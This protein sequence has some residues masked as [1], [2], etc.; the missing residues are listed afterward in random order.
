[1][2]K[3]YYVD[4]T[5]FLNGQELYYCGYDYRPRWRYGEIPELQTK[6]YNDFDEVYNNSVL[7]NCIYP[8]ETFWKHRKYLR[9]GI[10]WDRNITVFEKD[11]KEV[12]VIYR[13][14][15]LENYTMEKLMKELY[16]DEFV[17]YC[18]DH[19]MSVCPIGGV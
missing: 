9:G 19:G 17:E 13:I 16:A 7:F 14:R 11:F 2:K 10:D 8:D 3:I 15:E 5:E 1:M 18:K 12:K 6:I 4:S